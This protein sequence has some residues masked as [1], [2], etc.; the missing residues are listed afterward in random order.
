[1]LILL[2]PA[3]TFAASVPRLRRELTTPRLLDHTRQLVDVMRGMSVADIA[4]LMRVNPDIAAR[5]AEEYADLELPF[6][7]DNALPA[8]L[9]FSGE[10]YRGLDADRL[11][12][13]DLT[14]AQKTLRILSGL[15][16][17]IRP[18]DL[19]APY[20]LEMGTRLATERGTHLYDFWGT[21]LTDMLA[22]DLTASPGADVVVNLA[23][24]EYSDAVDL[25]AL[26]VPVISPRFEDTDARGRRTVVT[27][28]AKHARG[29]MAAWLVQSRARTA[30]DVLGFDGDGYAY[31]PATSTPTQPVFWRPFSARP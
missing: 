31:D 7:R 1:M 12:A 3:K 25:K 28:Y 17:V 20:R 8:L 26:D 2:S 11:D 13:R 9:A 30:T 16:G 23:S 5:T 14:E 6:T 4:T 21:H 19:I 27:V 29:A 18:L 10:A 24:K 15:Y 22:E